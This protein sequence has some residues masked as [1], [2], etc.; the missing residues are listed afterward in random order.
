M[1]PKVL[2]IEPFTDLRLE[3]AA[4]LR[5]E[6]YA[7]DAVATAAEG[8]AELDARPYEFVVVDLESTGDFTTTFAPTANVI[9]LTEDESYRGS[10][11]TLLK[12]FTRDELI[13]RFTN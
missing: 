12:P 8:A 2:V 6:H 7:C 9:V 3:I 10:F 13:A 1:F 5:R 11:P 4:T